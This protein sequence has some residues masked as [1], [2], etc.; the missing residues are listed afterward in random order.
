M[1]IATPAACAVAVVAGC[2]LAEGATGARP[3]EAKIGL[4]FLP[5][6]TAPAGTSVVMPIRLTNGWTGKAIGVTLTSDR[7][8]LGQGLQPRLHPTAGER[9]GVR[10]G[11]SPVGQSA[12]CGS[13]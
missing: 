1:R 5:S 9:F 2:Y 11:I 13:R 7:S 6:A 8:H 4:T 12:S 10:W 3:P